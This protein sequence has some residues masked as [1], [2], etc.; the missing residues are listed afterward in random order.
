MRHAQWLAAGLLAVA[1]SL[2]A[3][4]PAPPPA[5]SPIRADL[6]AAWRDASGQLRWPPNDG[7]TDP[8]RPAT[9]PPGARMVGMVVRHHRPR[10]GSCGVD[11]E[12][13]GFAVD[14]LRADF[15]PLSWMRVC[16]HVPDMER[17]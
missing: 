11:I 16:R 7:C 10:Y 8:E 12:I 1:A 5:A 15:D 3:C 6:P 2:A 9:L 14:S 4:T 13:A 17:V